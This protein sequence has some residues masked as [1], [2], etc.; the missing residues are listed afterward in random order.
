MLLFLVRFGL[1]V[2][3]IRIFVV[4]TFN[5]PSESM[6]PRLW[7]GDFLIVDKTRYGWSRYS[8]PYNWPLIPGRIFHRQPERGDVVVFKHPID[9]TDYVKRVIGLPGDTVQVVDGQLIINGQAVA[10]R[11]VA[12]FI[13]PVSPNMLGRGEPPCFL[14]RFEEAAANGGR[15]CRYPQFEEQLPNGR[16]YEVLDLVDTDADFTGV[17]QVPP[18]HMFVM[19]DNRD[20][21][22]DSRFPAAAGAG[23]GVVPQD[24]LVG[25]A[26][27]TVFSTDGSAIWYKPWT[28]FTATRADRIGEGF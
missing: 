27:V 25:R 3:A 5:I 21:S 24:R 11:R 1:V 6:Q 8:V 17:Y 16:R 19:G 26:L 20:R 12:D 13:I 15:E 2:L 28:W 23:V 7:V 9:G 14:P 10:R 18:G 4:S 22:Y